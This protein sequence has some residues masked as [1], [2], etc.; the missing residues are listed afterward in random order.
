MERI[1][2]FSTS[3]FSETSMPSS[4]RITVPSQV[5]LSHIGRT[6]TQRR[7]NQ[8]ISVLAKAAPTSFY[9]VSNI[10]PMFVVVTNRCF[11]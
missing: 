5:A 9:R 7:I 4:A 3:M 6:D 8:D 1:V 11:H 2:L 10:L